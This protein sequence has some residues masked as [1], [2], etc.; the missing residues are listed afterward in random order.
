[1]MADVCNSLENYEQKSGG[2]GTLFM[3][4]FFFPHNGLEYF[5][6]VF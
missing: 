3:S 5:P 4:I 1:M 2:G 6:K